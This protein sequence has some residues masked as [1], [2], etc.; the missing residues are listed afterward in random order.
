MTDKSENGVKFLNK[1]AE[2]PFFDPHI[3]VV[4][5]CFEQ[6]PLISISSSKIRHERQKF[7]GKVNSVWIIQK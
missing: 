1:R 3:D 5:P 4:Y 6:K 2:I 7:A